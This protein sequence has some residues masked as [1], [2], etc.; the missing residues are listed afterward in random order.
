MPPPMTFFL[1]FNDG[2]QMAITPNPTPIVMGLPGVASDVGVMMPG[3]M[4]QLFTAMGAGAGAGTGTGSANTQD[5]LNALF[6]QAQ[7]QSHG[8]P[9]TSTAF[10][11]KLPV[12]VWSDKVKAGQRQDECPICLSDFESKDQVISL[13]CGHLYHKVCG[14]QWLSEHNVCPTC[15]YKLPTQQEEP[16]AQAAAPATAAA[17]ADPA[18]SSNTGSEQQLPQQRASRTRPRSSMMMP[19]RVVRRR[20]GEVSEPNPE[21]EAEQ[22]AAS[23]AASASASASAS[24]ENDALDVMMDEEAD[25]LVAEEQQAAQSS[26]STSTLTTSTTDMD[27]DSSMDQDA[28]VLL[29]STSTQN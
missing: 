25:R 18:A 28:E 23:A 4:S 13:P 22:A 26:T 2:M 19:I 15:R 17:T 21:P 27:V 10:L 12:M 16:Q 3:L 14:L 20:V 24:L 7:Q 29:H 11:E 6:M 5:I 1:Q 9:P 8:P